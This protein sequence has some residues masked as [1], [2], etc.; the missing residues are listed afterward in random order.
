MY[1]RGHALCRCRARPFF[2]RLRNRDE[3]CLVTLALPVLPA[4]HRPCRSSAYSVALPLL[5]FGRTAGGHRLAGVFL[6]HEHHFQDC[7]TRSAR[8]SW[9]QSAGCASHSSRCC[10]KQSHRATAL[11][12]PS[13][14]SFG[15]DGHSVALNYSICAP[16]TSSATR[17]RIGQ[18]RAQ[19]HCWGN[20]AGV[21][22][23]AIRASSTA[24][25]A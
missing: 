8:D 3:V 25:P 12:C 14:G 20:D 19:S 21:I 10:A 15:G 1:F 23:W 16:A 24:Q 17:W 4:H 6:P 18:T 7:A 11:T 5:E 13:Q 2:S 9:T 22:A